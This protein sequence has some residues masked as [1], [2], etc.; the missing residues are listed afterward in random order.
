M[1]KVSFFLIHGFVL[2]AVWTFFGLFQIATNRYFKH[3]W[4]VN[5]WLHRVS[6]TIVLVT[7]LLYGC[8]GYL[9]LM[10]VKD[11]VHAPMGLAVTAVVL[12]LAVTG[13]ITRSRL[14]RANDNQ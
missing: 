2:W 10:F 3:H 12:L 7:T 4:S 9:K 6:G 8:V 13:V 5:M 11:D 14:M 1:A